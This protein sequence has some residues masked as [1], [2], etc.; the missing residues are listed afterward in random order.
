MALKQR[1][2]L[3]PGQRFLIENTDEGLSKNAP[4]RTLVESKHRAK[5]RNCYGRITSRRRGGGHKRLYRVIDFFR[6]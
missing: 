6:E 5:G 1:R 3:T 4:E 2:P